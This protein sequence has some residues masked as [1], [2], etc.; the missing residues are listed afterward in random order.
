MV[1]LTSDT[2]AK[3]IPV[4]H[5]ENSGDCMLARSAGRKLVNTINLTANNSSAN[6]NFAQLTGTVKI[7]ELFFEIEDATTLTN[8]TSVYVDLWDGT[9]SVDVTLDGITLSGL[10]V[11]T[12]FIKADKATSVMLLANNSQCRVTEASDPKKIAA[13]FD[14]TQKDST[15]T[16]LRFNYTTTDAPINAKITTYV[17][18]EPVDGGA[19]VAV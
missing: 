8:C 3:L 18:Y 19:L 15:N 4:D 10:A 9:N 6:V 17:V 11:G 1:Q 5:V 13:R 7:Y 2:L 16:Y 14:V 12:Y